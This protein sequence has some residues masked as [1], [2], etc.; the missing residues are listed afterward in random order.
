MHAYKLLLSISLHY[1][2]V[3]ATLPHQCNYINPMTSATPQPNT[4][5]HVPSPS[6][7]SQTLASDCKPL[8]NYQY[9]LVAL[10]AL[11]GLSLVVLALVTTGWVCT[12]RSMKKREARESSICIRYK[13]KHSWLNNHS[14]HECLSKMV[15]FNVVGLLMSMATTMIMMMMMK[16]RLM[17]SDSFKIP[18]TMTCILHTQH[19]H[20]R[21]WLWDLLNHWST[22]EFL[23][24]RMTLLISPLSWLKMIA[25]CTIYSTEVRQM[26]HVQE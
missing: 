19:S 7:E 2:T 9:P 1:C 23:R 10:G 26:V 25:R 14:S 15:Y 22:K 16:I 8:E 11:Q 13:C 20:M 12:C 21:R 4:Q 17:K 18:R 3:S 24:L 5:Y 6:T